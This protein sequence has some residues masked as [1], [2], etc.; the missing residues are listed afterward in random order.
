MRDPEA[1]WEV[2]ELGVR[3]G[4]AGRAWGPS[5]SRGDPESRADLM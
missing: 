4:R 1:G 3:A 5:E 2:G